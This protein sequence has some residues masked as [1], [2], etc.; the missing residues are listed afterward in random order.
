M[1]AG[2]RH[3]KDEVISSSF[4][5]AFH[6][7]NCG[8]QGSRPQVV[9][10]GGIAGLVSRYLGPLPRE[11]R[12]LTRLSFCIA[13]LDVVKIRLQL[14]T[15]ALSPFGRDTHGALPV[16]KKILR[17]EGLTVGVSLNPKD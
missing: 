6:L 15:H 12:A 13:P 16:V 2:G 5:P 7:T 17:E 1:S 4:V 11:D 9:L 8:Y 3:L 10:A 14:Q